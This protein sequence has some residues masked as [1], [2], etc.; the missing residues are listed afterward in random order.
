MQRSMGTL[1]ITGTYVLNLSNTNQLIPG[2]A[3]GHFDRLLRRLINS[4]LMPI[5]RTMYEGD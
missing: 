5:D 2:P 4:G 3:Q 1:C